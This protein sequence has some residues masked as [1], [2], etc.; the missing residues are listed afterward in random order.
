M[1]SSSKI[2]TLET[3]KN[4]QE[5]FEHLLRR[6]TKKSLKAIVVQDWKKGNKEDLEHLF[7]NCQKNNS[8]GI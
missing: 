8:N 3:S 6:E 1:W 4:H 5:F 2:Y 7:N